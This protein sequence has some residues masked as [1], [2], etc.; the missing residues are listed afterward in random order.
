[1]KG[2]TLPRLRTALGLVLLLAGAARARAEG[3]GLLQWSGAVGGPDQARRLV[4]RTADAWQ[5]WWSDRGK[6]APRALGSDE[7]AVVVA[8]GERRTGGY[9]VSFLS[10]REDH[11]QLA[12]RYKVKTPQPEAVVM[13]MITRPWAVAVVPRTALPVAFQQLTPAEADGARG[14]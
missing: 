12:V 1:M 2:K 4:I 7:M 9:S 6:P 3:T 8:L 14:E 11:E 10:V 13:Q 5:A